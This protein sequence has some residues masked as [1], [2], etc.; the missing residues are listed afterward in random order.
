MGAGTTVFRGVHINNRRRVDALCNPGNPCR[1][2]TTVKK[3]PAKCESASRTEGSTQTCVL[4]LHRSR[5]TL[6]RKLTVVA[7]DSGF[8]CDLETSVA[9]NQDDLNDPVR[10]LGLSKSASE[11]LAS[12]K[13]SN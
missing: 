5:W 7:S 10:N 12:W 4:M 1:I 8:E 6:R 9:F 2:A 3:K 13:L 11:I